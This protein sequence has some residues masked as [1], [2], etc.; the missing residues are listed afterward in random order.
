[1]IR[2][3]HLCAPI[4]QR[5]HMIATV[6]PEQFSVFCEAIRSQVPG[7]T[8]TI[9]QAGAL[10]VKGSPEPFCRIPALFPGSR[11]IGFE[12]DKGLCDRLNAEAEPGFAYYPVAL[13]KT[14]E[15]R[16]LYQ[17]AHPMCTSLY[18]PDNEFTSCYN[19]LN[20]MLLTSTSSVETVSLDKFTEEY[21]IPD[22]DF[23]K[24]DIQGAELEVFQN[25]AD[26]LRNVSFIISEVEFVPLYKHQPLFG[27]VCSFL[28]GQHL[29]FHKFLGVAGRTLT[30]LD[31]RSNPVLATQ[32]LWGDALFIR[33][34]FEIERL[35]PDKLLKLGILA[36]L[37]CSPD[38]ALYCFRLYDAISHTTISGTVPG[39]VPR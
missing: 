35:A 17:A 16:T 1:M 7:I 15:R 5:N 12:L 26:T 21:S 36:Y 29:M 27:D 2:S 31:V 13:G 6:K 10:P 14:R 3:A 37:Y 33:H 20:T 23:I 39:G 9:L 38:V 28:A 22:V 32:H 18:E 34:I 19:T 4:P 8:F 30:T 25:A 11:I 24:I